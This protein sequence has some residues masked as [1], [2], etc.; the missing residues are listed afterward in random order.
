MQRVIIVTLAL[1]VF[2]ACGPTIEAGDGSASADDTTTTAS[3]TTRTTTGPGTLTTT[4][5]E[6][7]GSDEVDSGMMSDVPSFACDNPAHMCSTPIACEPRICGGPGA[8]FDD[9]GCL[10]RSC[11]SDDDCADT[12][13][14]YRPQDWG[15]CASSG[16]TCHDAPDG[17]CECVFDPDCSGAWCLPGD[18]APPSGGCDDSTQ[19]ACEASGCELV[20]GRPILPANGACLCELDEP[21]CIWTWPDTT[22]SPGNTA[23]MRLDDSAVMAFPWSASPP[24]LGWIACEDVDFPPPACICAPN[25]PCAMN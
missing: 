10:R 21:Q 4:R 6:D 20:L 13:V 11:G 16:G 22:L 8:A 3:T 15:G 23:Y 7:T 1:V 12:E 19:N 2:S 24:P 9:D 14:C 25:L 18:E 5:P 17:G